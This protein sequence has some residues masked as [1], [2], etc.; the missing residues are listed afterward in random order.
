M[1]RRPAPLSAQSTLSGGPTIFIPWAANAF[2]ASSDVGS[3][4]SF[5]ASRMKVS[6]V[7]AGLLR[8]S[9]QSSHFPAAPRAGDGT[10]ETSSV[11]LSFHRQTREPQAA[12]RGNSEWTA[13]EVGLEGSGIEERGRATRYPR[14]RAALKGRRS[15][16]H[17]DGERPGQPVWARQRTESRRRVLAPRQVWMRSASFPASGSMAYPLL[18][19]SCDGKSEPS[20][21]RISNETFEHTSSVEAT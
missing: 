13:G 7:P 19:S 5:V 6:N 11:S 21:S 9:A 15:G 16:P 4:L 14:A 12:S 1:V 20:R 17:G 18:G 10:R 8:P 2:S 3:F